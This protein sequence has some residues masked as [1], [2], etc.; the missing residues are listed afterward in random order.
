GLLS[1]T[2][3]SAAVRPILLGI[4]LAEADVVS[5]DVGNDGI[6]ELIELA[7]ILTLVSDGILVDRE[8]LARHWGPATRAL[9]LAM[10]LTLA[11]LA[12]GA[13]FLFGELTWAES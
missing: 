10:P 9:V 4:V 8:L 2:V 11:L 5:I 7:L 3:M 1:G 13:N 6:V 12:V